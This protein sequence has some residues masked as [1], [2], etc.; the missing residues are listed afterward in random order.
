MCG[1]VLGD[2]VPYIRVVDEN[3]AEGPL[4]EIYDEVQ[5]SRGRLSN[6]LQIESL[7]PRGLKAHL[8]LYMEL[9]FGKGPLSRKERELIAVAVSAATGCDYCVVHHS[10]A[11]GNYAD[12]AWVQDVAAGD[13]DLEPRE[14]ALVDFAR[15]LTLHPGEGREQAVTALRDAG[16]SDEA[17]LHA[18]ETTA[19]FNFVNRIASGLGVELEQESERD[20]AY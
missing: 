19:Y 7:N 8:G 1:C 17:I 11:L 4:F 12:K 5:R 18:T 9:V 2:D 3:D 14:Q 15:G 6:I 13:A 16:F 10:E 20:Y